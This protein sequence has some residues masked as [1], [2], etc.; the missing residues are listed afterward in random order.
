MNL[1]ATTKPWSRQ[2]RLIV[3]NLATSLLLLMGVSLFLLGLMAS[4]PGPRSS[5]LQESNPPLTIYRNWLGALWHG[6][7]ILSLEGIAV[8]DL[9]LPALRI[10]IGLTLAALVLATVTALLVATYTSLK[11]APLSMGFELVLYAISAIPIFLL[12]YGVYLSWI[13]WFRKIP[14]VAA[15]GDKTVNSSLLLLLAPVVILMLGDGNL[16]NLYRQFKAELGRIR[17]ED[18]V[19]GAIASGRSP[20]SRIIRNFRLPLAVIVTSR[21]TVLL[22]GAIVLEA[23]FN[24]KGIGYLSWRAAQ[25][26]DFN[27]LLSI[28]LVS[29]LIVRITSLVGTILRI[30]LDPRLRTVVPR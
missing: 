13:N 16:L 19:L 1:V 29:V 27:L 26:R 28:T 5:D 22:G 8:S 23:I 9:I 15:S 3:Q 11:P 4:A 20:R 25:N 7:A 30:V 17:G 14:L 10:T 18:F 24:L 6:N 12:G 2:A 21:L